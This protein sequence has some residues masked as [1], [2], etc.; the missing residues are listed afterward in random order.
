MFNILNYVHP[1]SFFIAFCIGI[2]LVYISTPD[3][4]IIFKYPTPNSKNVY[5][6]DSE[7]CYK[8]I[9][10]EVDCSK[11]KNVIETELQHTNKE[12]KK[13]SFIDT[14]KNMF[15]SKKED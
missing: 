5:K 3:P 12:K 13:K 7:M 10:E 15:K 4:I 14:V 11:H 8:Y 1:M 9:H 2:F 6:D